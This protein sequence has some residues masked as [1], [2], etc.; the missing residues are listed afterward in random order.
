MSLQVR[1]AVA[2]DAAPFADL[3]RPYVEQT[4]ITFETEAPDAR[5]FLSRIRNI[6]RLNPWIT[7][8]EQEEVIGYA[9]YH[10]FHSRAAYQ[11]W[12]EISVYLRQDCRGRGIGTRLMSCLEECAAIQGYTELLSLVTSSNPA[13]LHLH[14]RCGYQQLGLLPNCGFKLGQWHSVY[15]LGKT[16]AAPI[17]PCPIRPLDQV[18]SQIEQRLC[19]F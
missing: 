11:W 7:V 17:A 15:Y 5:E 19:H 6:T 14:Q 18:R 10:P 16:L 3:Y 2:A 9:Y 1:L 4:A 8:T 12:A 13:S